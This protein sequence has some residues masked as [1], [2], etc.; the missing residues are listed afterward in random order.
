M[1]IV[2]HSC[3]LPNDVHLAETRNDF[4]V[5]RPSLITMD[6]GRYSK[7]TKP[8]FHKD[9]AHGKKPLVVSYKHLTICDMQDAIF[10]FFS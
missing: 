2:R 10:L 7:H 4:I 6:P 3:T 8:F 1:R 5:K 9:F